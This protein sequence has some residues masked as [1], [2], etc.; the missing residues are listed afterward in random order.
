MNFSFWVKRLSYGRYRSL[1]K[2]KLSA[3]KNIKK[4][5]IFRDFSPNI[6]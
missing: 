3:A 5:A 2:K 6:L 1:K 4:M